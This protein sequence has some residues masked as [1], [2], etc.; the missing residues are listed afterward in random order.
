MAAA[1]S[2]AGASAGS[3]KRPFTWHACRQAEE[4]PDPKFESS[5]A[6]LF[7]R[8]YNVVVN[9][10]P[11]CTTHRPSR[12]ESAVV[13]NWSREAAEQVVQLEL[14]FAYTLQNDAVR[15]LGT[16]ISAKIDM[17]REYKRT[18]STASTS[19]VKVLA[20]VDESM[21]CLQDFTTMMLDLEKIKDLLLPKHHQDLLSILNQIAD[22]PR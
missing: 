19:A 21:E 2:D 7:L 1:C 10:G 15:A 4:E 14:E 8:L 3:R 20:M 13:Q 12:P 17:Y 6:K 16:A 9:T 5:L 18:A 11:R 22:T